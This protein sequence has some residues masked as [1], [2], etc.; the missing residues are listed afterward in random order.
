M[1]AFYGDRISEHI[2]RLKNGGL[3]CISVPIARS[4]TQE[5]SPQELADSVGNVPE[6]MRLRN[7][8]VIVHRP[9]SEVFS[10]TTMASFEGAPCCGPFHPPTFLSKQNW[11]AY[12]TGHVQNVRPGPRLPDGNRA[13]VADVIVR[14]APLAD[15]VENKEA[16]E[17]SCGY[18]C[19]Y[20]VQDDGS[21][22]QRNIR[23]NHVAIL[24]GR[25][26]AGSHV[27]IYDHAVD[28]VEELFSKIGTTLARVADR[29]PELTPE[30][31]N[32][33]VDL[34]PAQV[35]DAA[36]GAE[37]YAEQMRRFWRR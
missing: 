8:R 16:R 22:V 2:G 35:M 3:A 25:G 9:E 34:A 31:H 23:G 14:D 19:D 10:R 28:P 36:S 32:L 18:S 13:L 4:G 17:V 5:Y 1:Q 11:R 24:S 7:G 6:G 21:L 12:A 26:R 33:I 30:I 29:Y 15:M 37:V 20:E 27:R